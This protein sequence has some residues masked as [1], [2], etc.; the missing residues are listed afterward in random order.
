MQKLVE[1][2]HVSKCFPGVVALNDVNLELVKGEVNVLIGEN[3]AGKSTLMKILSGALKQDEG[4]VVIEGEIMKVNSP[5]TAVKMGIGMIYQELNLIPELS[6]MKNIFLGNEKKKGC[7]NDD[8]K[9]LDEAKKYLDMIHLD[10]DPRVLVKDLSIGTQQ[11]VEIAKALSKNS[12]VLVLDEPTSSL[13]DSEI[14]ELFRI[15]ELLKN[16]GVGMFYISHRLEELYEVGDRVTIMRDGNVIGTYHINDITMEQMIEKIAGRKI[17]NLY[18][19]TVKKLGENVLEVKKLSGEKFSNVSITVRAGE[20]VGLS[21]L[22]GAG[23][24]ELVR[25]IFGI[26]KYHS[27]EVC[28]LGKKIPKNNPRKAIDCGLGLL[29]EDRKVQ[30]LAL[31]KSVRENIVITDLNGIGYKGIVNLPK[32][33]KICRDHVKRLTI[34]TPSIEKLAGFL[35]GGTQQKV[36]IAKWLQANLKLF[37]FDEPTRGI[38]VGAKSD[39]YRLMDDL[40]EQGASIL[41]ISSDLPEI[42]GMSDRIYVMANGKITGELNHDEASQSKILQF[43]YNQ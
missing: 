39:I 3:G 2:R 38:D 29:P 10:V 1:F 13:T 24:T 4:E 35:S 42:I 33:R 36:V 23:R 30:G 15:I 43:A 6:I 40:V 28:L 34:A 11:M 5:S 7:F 25:A 37:I 27:G 12:K 21:G 16:Q 14:K 22:M 17:T 41:M 8:K 9:M 20:I 32:E 31:E 19:H 26:D 18:P